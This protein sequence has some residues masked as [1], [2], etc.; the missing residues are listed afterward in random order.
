MKKAGLLVRVN[1]GD[2]ADQR[3]KYYQIPV[4]FRSSLPDGTRVLDFGS[5]VLRFENA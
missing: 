5:V 1:P 2:D 4:A 3:A